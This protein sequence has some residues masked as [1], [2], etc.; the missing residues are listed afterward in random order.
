MV[1]RCTLGVLYHWYGSSGETGILPSAICSRTSQR[2]KFGNETIASPPTRSISRRISS[3]RRTACS[4]CD[5]ITQSKEPAS[6]PASPRSRSLWMTFTLF[7][8]QA[9]TLASSMSIPYPRALR[10]SFRYLSRVPSPQP[11]SSTVESGLTQAAIAWKS[12]RPDSVS[13]SRPFIAARRCRRS[14]PARARGS[15]H[16]RA[17]THR[18]RAARRSEVRARALDRHLQPLAE[19]QQGLVD[20]APALVGSPDPGLVRRRRKHL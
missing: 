13:C 16:R 19:E 2:P 11:R 8:T 9:S 12:E 4:V 18:A 7:F 3:V 10:V 1:K 5:R 6:K 14:R 15:A 17:G 20:L